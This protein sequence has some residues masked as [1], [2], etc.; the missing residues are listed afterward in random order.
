MLVHVRDRR[1][2]REAWSFQRDVDDVF[3]RAFGFDRFANAPAPT[4]LQVVPDA[5]GVT[6][7]AELPGVDPA[8]IKIGVEGRTLS[9]SGE[10]A[11]E[12]RENGAYQ[13]R[14]RA[15]GTLA[16]KLQLS[17]DL[18]AAAISAEARA[19]LELT[20]LARL[21]SFGDGQGETAAW[22]VAEVAGINA[23]SRY[24]PA[25]QHWEVIEH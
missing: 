10:R 14:E 22:A 17:D 4:A 3:R 1:P 5:D 16:Q 8:E 6:I 24:A 25:G 7:R 21:F 20:N 9:I 19:I 12:K 2:T 15:Y 18:D 11:T 23:G 13:L